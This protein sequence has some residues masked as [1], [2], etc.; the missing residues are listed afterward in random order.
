VVHQ[1]MSCGSC[2]VKA[3]RGLR[4]KSDKSKNFHLCQWCFW[5]GRIPLE[6]RDDVFKEFNTFSKSSLSTYGGGSLKKSLQ[7]LS[8]SG[9]TKTPKFPEMEAPLDLGGMV[10]SSPLPSVRSLPRNPPPYSQQQ[11]SEADFHSYGNICQQQQQSHSADDPN[12][13]I[14]EHHLIAQYAQELHQGGGGSSTGGGDGGSYINTAPDPGGHMLQQS[15]ELVYELEKKNQEIMHDIER[16][17]R[18]HPAKENK[19]RGGGGTM[20]ELQGLR[21]HKMELE[22]RL[23]ELQ[24]ARRDLMEELDE[25]M[26]LLK[27]QPMPPQP[28]QQQVTSQQPHQIHHQNHFQ[29]QFHE[30]TQPH[31]HI[32]QIQPGQQ[33]LSGGK[34]AVVVPHQQPQQAHLLTADPSVSAAETNHSYTNIAGIVGIEQQQHSARVMPPDYPL[35]EVPYQDQ[36]VQANYQYS[37]THYQQQQHEDQSV[38][39]ESHYSEVSRPPVIGGSDPPPTITSAAGSNAGSR[40]SGG[41]K[42]KKQHGVKRMSTKRLE[43]SKAVEMDYEN[44]VAPVATAVDNIHCASGDAG[45]PRTNSR[46]ASAVSSSD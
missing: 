19:A 44:D 14:I 32:Q 26:K 35:Y 11:Q 12:S 1:G 10:Q 27:V 7:C 4:Y 3:F 20:S 31:Y 36:Q 42:E 13:S 33:V 5:R 9:K 29:Q 30:V 8:G 40:P 15:R 38:Y 6:H 41:L 39:Y 34:G 2:G 23:D 21:S 24:C 18:S 16:L 45:H 17:R 43:K 46:T 22:S 37:T 25:L 28:Q